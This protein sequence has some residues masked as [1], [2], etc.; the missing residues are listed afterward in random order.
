MHRYD[1]NT[2][3]KCIFQWFH[4]ASNAFVLQMHLLG[5]SLRPLRGKTVLF[6]IS[7]MYLHHMFTSH[8]ISGMYFC[9]M[10]TS[11]KCIFAHI[12]PKGNFTPCGLSFP[13]TLIFLSPHTLQSRVALTAYRFACPLTAARYTI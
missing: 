7:G 11:R 10:F 13:H 1:R 6:Y 8:S 4:S 12:Y 2:S 5:S 9:H 3:Q